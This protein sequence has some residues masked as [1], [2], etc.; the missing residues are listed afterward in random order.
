MLVAREIARQMGVR[1]FLIGRSTHTLEQALAAEREGAGYIGIGPVFATPTKP[2]YPAVGL[3]LVRQVASRVRIPH[4]AIGG[5]D[6]TNVESVLAAG[7][8]RIA[9]VR[10]V[11]GALDIAQGARELKFLLREKVGAG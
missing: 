11:A 10:A 9:V 3:G 5:I 6:A 4:V 7:A 2:G 1:N 8:E